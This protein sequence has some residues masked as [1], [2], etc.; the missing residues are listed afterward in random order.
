[1]AWKTSLNQFGCLLRSNW[2]QN[3]KVSNIFNKYLEFVFQDEVLGT[4]DLW[5]R[6]HIH[7][8]RSIFVY[9]QEKQVEETRTN[10]PLRLEKDVHFLQGERTKL[11][12]GADR[13]QGKSLLERKR[14]MQKN[15]TDN[16]A[17]KSKFLNRSAHPKPERKTIKPKP[18]KESEIKSNQKTEE[19][20]ENP[21]V[22]TKKEEGKEKAEKEKKIKPKSKPKSLPKP[23]PEPETESESKTEPEP[24]PNSADEPEPEPVSVGTVS[25]DSSILNI[26]SKKATK[27]LEN[28]TRSRIKPPRTKPGKPKPTPE[29]QL[30][31]D[32]SLDSQNTKQ[33]QTRNE[34]KEK[35]KPKPIPP[36]QVQSSHEIEESED[37][38]ETSEDSSDDEEDEDDES[39][40]DD[41]EESDE[42][43]S[44]G[45]RTTGISTT[46]GT[47]TNP[48]SRD[49]RNIRK[50][51]V[52]YSN[53]LIPIS[54]QLDGVYV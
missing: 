19:S 34:N 48:T 3:S 9:K 10:Q 47:E 32:T 23:E 50:S 45:D 28:L 27:K 15:N 35:K 14:L 40:E 29:N 26:L 31:P 17:Q 16:T 12:S 41:D 42:S 21:V 6:L 54:L 22:E 24:Q 51:K 39:D 38:D 30:N 44:E 36:P 8:V 18:G 11:S 25:E 49:D 33:D 46:S 20:L 4:V 37:E 2:S 7:D 43:V 13:H 52:G 53:V 5:F 1:M